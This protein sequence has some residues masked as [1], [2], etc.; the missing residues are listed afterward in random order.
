M[1]LTEHAWEGIYYTPEYITDYICRNT[2]IPYLSK[3]NATT[4]VEELINEHKDN[5]EVLEKKLKDLR[6]LDPACGSGAFLIK[7][8]DVLLEIHR[9]II[10]AK[11]VQGKYEKRVLGKRGQEERYL[12]FSKYYDEDEARKIIEDNIYGVDINEESVAITKLSLYLKIAREKKKLLDLSKNIKCGNRLIDDKEI[13][14]KAFNWQKEFPEIFRQGGFDI[15]IGNPPYVRMEMFKEIK[16]YLREKYEAHADRSDLYVY[17]YEKAHQLLADTGLLGFIRSNTFMTT[18]YGYELRRFL[19]E[20]TEIQKI[21]NFGETQFF[22]GATTYPGLFFFKKVREVSDKHKVHYL[23][24]RNLEIQEFL[25]FVEHEPVLITQKSL[26]PRMWSFESPENQK[27]LNKISKKS[28]LLKDYCEVPLMGIK[29]GLN[30]AFIIDQYKRDELIRE[31][32]KNAELIKPCLMEKNLKR[33]HTPSV[34]KYL[35]YIPRGIDINQYASIKN[36]LTRY[37]DKLEKRATKQEW[38]EL[39]QPQA[40]YIPLMAATKIIYVDIASKPTFSLDTEK[41]YLAN[42]VYFLPTNDKYLLG[43]LNSALIK[44]FIFLTSRAYRG[45]FVTFRS[46]YVERIPIKEAAD[47]EK[48]PR[49]EK[50]ESMIN[51]SKK[52]DEKKGKFIR[53]VLSTFKLDNQS[54][55]LDSFWKLSF[56]D[57]QK[58]VYRLSKKK[59]SLT[60]Q[61]E[62]EDYF[63]DY[64]EELTELQQ[65]IGETDKAIDQRVYQLYELTPEEIKIIE[66]GI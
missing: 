45:G 42:S 64:K 57:F 63:N 31:Y 36:E 8:V 27:I 16:P 28:A 34:N 10:E 47:K 51:L 2:I 9:A 6:I 26:N 53:R 18:G 59:L 56:D 3:N 15:V 61:D 65:K 29:T 11:A 33:W 38:Y 1:G 23:E 55:K 13:D 58:K 43:I 30:D 60:E 37:K 41:Y 22:E 46:I 50:V 21:L 48:K 24:D 54:K 52:A 62:W 5:F 32:S 20:K 12:S 19:Q 44:W 66:E 40:R 35:I 17:F 7:A 49:I 25:S 39:Q 14:K 4:T